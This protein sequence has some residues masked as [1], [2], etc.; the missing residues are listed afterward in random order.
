MA[1]MLLLLLLHATLSSAGTTTQQ[2]RQLYVNGDLK[3][4]SQPLPVVVQTA[5][6]SSEDSERHFWHWLHKQQKQSEVRHQKSR[7]SRRWKEVENGEEEHSHPAMLEKDEMTH[8][9]PMLEN[10]STH[11]DESHDEEAHNGIHVASWRW[12]EIGIYITFTSFIIVAG[13][14]KVAFHH[15]HVISSR[16]P[17]SWLNIKYNVWIYLHVT[18]DLLHIRPSSLLILLGTAVGGILY[19]AGVG[20]CEGVRGATR[21]PGCNPVSN[22]DSDETFRFPTFTPKL[23]FLILLPP[24][25]LESSYSLYDRAFADNI[26]TVLFYAVIGTI[27]NTFVIG[28]LLKSQ[29]LRLSFAK[30]EGNR[31]ELTFPCQELYIA[32]SWVLTQLFG[33]LFLSLLQYMSLSPKSFSTMLRF[34]DVLFIEFEKTVKGFSLLGLVTIGWIG[35]VRVPEESNVEWWAGPLYTLQATDCLVFSSLISAVDPVAVLAI[36]Q[37]VGINKDLYFLV[38]GESL[39]ND[40]VTVVLYSMMVVFAQMEGNVAGGQYALGIVSFFTISLG[41]LGIGILC[42]LLT[43]LITRTTSEVRVV[44]PLAVLGMAYFSYLCAELF[45]FSGIISCIGCG[46]V[47][48]HYAFANVSH[49]SYTTVKYFIKMLSSTSDAIIFLFLGMVLVNDVHEWHTGFVLW[50]LLLCLVVRFLG[51]FILTAI[52]NRFRLKPVNL[53]EQFIMAYGGL[54]GAVS[55]SLVEMLLPSVIQPRQMF[56][57]T[58][59]AVILFTVFVQGGTIKLFVRLLHIQKDSKTVKCLMNEMNETMFDHLCAGIEEICGHR[60]N[61]FFREKIEHIDEL[62]LRPIFTRSTDK[63]SLQRLF[64]K[65]TLSEHAANMYAGTGENTGFT[66][67]A[68]TAKIEEPAPEVAPKAKEPTSPLPISGDVEVSPLLVQSPLPGQVAHQFKKPMRG[69]YP[70]VRQSS[71]PP[72]SMMPAR[73][74]TPGSYNPVRPYNENVPGLSEFPEVQLRIKGIRGRQSRP[75]SGESTNSGSLDPDATAHAF[76]KALRTTSSNQYK[77]VYQK[78]NRNLIGDDDLPEIEMALRRRLSS[79]SSPMPTGGRFPQAVSSVFNSPLSSP[80]S[81]NSPKSISNAGGNPTSS[82][83]SGTCFPFSVSGETAVRPQGARR[84][85]RRSTSPTRNSQQQPSEYAIENERS[86]ISGLSKRP[87]LENLRPSGFAPLRVIAERD[88]EH[89]ASSLK[90]QDIENGEDVHPLDT[91]KSS[92][93]SRPSASRETGV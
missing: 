26:G 19:A 76:R 85:N 79:V 81:P 23:F 38:F 45:H 18:R 44:E 78:H 92:R 50:T 29:T 66:P 90:I 32:D 21:I 20:L 67:V 11:D 2:D 30:K 64:E 36:F 43:A 7:R 74:S 1:I 59:L 86:S 8:S 51:V 34:N 39:L 17:E 57:T 16:I 84:E 40:A 53:Q 70:L 87:R 3:Q 91:S 77:R 75:N 72:G 27:F 83:D 61:N 31:N 88:G 35:A 6:I 71:A 5:S 80:E 49:K 93:P 89:S 33:R 37:E 47:Q 15:A 41:G 63:N 24:I 13:L 68:S 82:F 54:R 28:G 4:V 9:S 10:R 46:L 60:G 25:I 65:L 73:A 69:K 48:A 22:S 58:T 12:D 42:G 55:F 56:V 14:A 52:A 62:Y